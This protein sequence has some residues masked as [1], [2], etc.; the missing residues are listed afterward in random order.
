ME[1]TENPLS[2]GLR[3]SSYVHYILDG[4]VTFVTRHAISSF[5]GASASLLRK[6]CQVHSWAVTAGSTR[7]D[8]T[9]TAGQPNYLRIGT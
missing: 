1:S 4:Q 9:C 8:Q 2:V 6:N 7:E 3:D 5:R